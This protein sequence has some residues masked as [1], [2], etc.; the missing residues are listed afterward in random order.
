MKSCLKVIVWTVLL[1]GVAPNAR[2]VLG[3]AREA[4]G[5]TD[6]SGGHSVIT[7]PFTRGQEL[8][9]SWTEVNP[10]RSNFNW[11]AID[12]A[13][14]F[15][16]DQNQVFLLKVGTVGSGGGGQRAALDVRS[17]RRGRSVLQGNGC[18]CGALYVWALYECEF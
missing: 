18:R 10:G 9:I 3:L 12:A 5:V 14:Q 16:D 1:S 11:T 15:A 6:R 4:Y 8:D 13:I 7:Y 17:E 2:A